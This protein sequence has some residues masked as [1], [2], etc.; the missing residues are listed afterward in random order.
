M[1]SI[2]CSGGASSWQTWLLLVSKF[3][4]TAEAIRL[5]KLF[6]YQWHRDCQLPYASMIQNVK[7]ATPG[8]KA[9][10]MDRRE[11]PQG[12]SSATCPGGLPAELRQA[13]RGHRLASAGLHSGAR[14]ETKQLLETTSTAV[15]PSAAGSAMKMRRRFAGCSAGWPASAPRNIGGNCSRRR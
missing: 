6:L 12:R 7:P 1:A 14:I 10:I 5:S 4:G 13:I 15:G 8:S 11:L 3:T 2:V 9:R